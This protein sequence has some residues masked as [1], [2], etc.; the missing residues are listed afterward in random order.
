MIISERNREEE[1]LTMLESAGE[2]TSRLPVSDDKSGYGR[3]GG[4][5]E[6]EEVLRSCTKVKVEVPECRDTLLQVKVPRV[7]VVILQIGPFQINMICYDTSPLKS[8]V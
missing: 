1:Q 4:T 5:K 8:E 7:K 3:L 2:R 6:V